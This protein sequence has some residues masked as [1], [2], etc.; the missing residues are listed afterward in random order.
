MFQNTKSDVQQFPHSGTD[1][2]Q[3]SFSVGSQAKRKLFDNV[4]MRSRDQC[5]EVQFF[6]KPAVAHF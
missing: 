3:G 6:T 1:N 4:A 5:G 2:L